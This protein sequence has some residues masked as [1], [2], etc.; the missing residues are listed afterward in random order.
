[1]ASNLQLDSDLVGTSQ[2]VRDGRGGPSPLGLSTVQVTV[3]A[4]SADNTALLHVRG[5][6][7]MVSNSGDGSVLLTLDI[8]R[9]WVLKQ[10]STGKTTALEL[11]AAD[12][13]NNN[14]NFLINTDGR[15][16]IG[17]TIPEAKLHVA[18]G[19]LLISNQGDGKV[20]LALGSERAWVFKQRGTGRTTALELTAADPANNNKNFLIMT[21]G[22]VGIG[23]RT[24]QSKL[25]VQ[26]SIT[27]SEDI[28][29][30]R[31]DCAEEF[32]IERGS[33]T[34]PG[35][36]MVIGGRRSLRHS[37]SAYDPRVAG[38]VSGAA[39]VGPGIVLGRKG[40]AGRNVAVALCGTVSCRADA[41]AR[42]IEVG[43][44]LTTSERPGHA[45]SAIDRDRSFGAIIGK[46]L[47]ELPRGVGVVPVLVALQ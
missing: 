7:V 18:N 20:I 21:D 10:R 36:V 29:L 32:D 42:P 13:D 30:V 2:A 17:T 5:G 28:V 1:M 39:G 27:V 38:V 22:R 40:R 37:T 9:A 41:T 33:E 12:P 14:K 11:T 24:P 3:G 31:A 26:G 8:E 44:M 4:G 19:E 34:E 23:T 43:D 6:A 16:G 47:G 46:A 45:M 25:D 15:V 35:T